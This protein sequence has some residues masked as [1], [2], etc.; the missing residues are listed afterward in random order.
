MR[1][2]VDGCL[3]QNCLAKQNNINTEEL[4]QRLKQQKWSKQLEV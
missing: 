4:H 2:P 3:S 1:V